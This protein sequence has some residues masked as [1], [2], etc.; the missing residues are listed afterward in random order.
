MRLFIAVE[1]PENM[2]DA[3]AETSADLRDC[4]QGRYVR[5]DMFHV[6]L[7]F[8]GELEAAKIPAL[9]S[10]IERIASQHSPIEISLG[11]LGSFGKRGNAILWQGFEG[12]CLHYPNSPRPRAGPSNPKASSSTRRTSD[13]TSL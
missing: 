10:I 2:L 4:V 3:L 12:R 7:A 11:E 6:T 1:L 8:L 5:P 9:E 13:R